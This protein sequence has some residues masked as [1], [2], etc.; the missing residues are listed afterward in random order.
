MVKLRAVSYLV[1]NRKKSSFLMSVDKFNLLRLVHSL[2]MQMKFFGTETT[3][4]IESTHKVQTSANAVR[5]PRTYLSTTCHKHSSAILSVLIMP[6]LAGKGHNKM[7]CGVC[8]SVCR[9]S[10]PNSRTTERPIELKIG[11]MEARHTSNS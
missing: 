5:Y 3:Q 11:R 10:R 4:I 2:F 1:N 9:M 6:R 8:P 7:G